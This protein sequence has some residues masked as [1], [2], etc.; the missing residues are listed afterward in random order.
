[1]KANHNDKKALTELELVFKS[2]KLRNNESK[3]QL[4]NVVPSI[5]TRYLRAT[6]YEIMKANHN[7]AIIYIHIVKVFKSYKLRNNESK[8]QQQ[9]LVG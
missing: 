8:S 3:S 1:M 5:S 2:Y 9:N 4:Y 6:S 7:T